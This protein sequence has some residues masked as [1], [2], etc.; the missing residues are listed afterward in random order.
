[1]PV[2]RL[3]VFLPAYNEQH[4]VRTAVESVSAVLERSGLSYEIIVVNDGSSDGTGDVVREMLPQVDGLRL[5][6][7]HP[8]RGYGGALQAGFSAS[9]GELIA[10]VPADN[11]FV[12][13]EIHLLLGEIE[14]ADIVSGWRAERQDNAV[15]RLFGSGWN[16]VVRVLFGRLCRDIDCGFKLV[17]RQVI[18]RVPLQSSGAMIDT[19]LLAGARARG[20][21][22]AEVP[23]T[24]LARIGGRATGADP[25]VIAR[26]FRDLVHYRLRLS[27]E[28][29]AE[30]A[31]S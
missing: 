7:H 27:R 18:E 11:Q 1:M 9:C 19:E 30:R 28:I 6:E 16:L 23:V 3:S 15:R 24:H 20:F 25:R 12:F 29:R 31:V 2:P 13:S 22:I 8:N 14:E 21:R 10:F 26:A 17:C 5:V 4:N